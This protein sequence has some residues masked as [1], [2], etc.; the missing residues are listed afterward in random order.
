MKTL[1]AVLLFSSL[2]FA[3]DKLKTETCIKAI[4]IRPA[5]AVLADMAGPYPAVYTPAIF[6]DLAEQALSC[7]LNP[8]LTAEQQHRWVLELAIVIH[9]RTEQDK[10]DPLGI[11]S[12]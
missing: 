11:R 6:D 4:Q 9:R 5:S 12:E 1:L 7:A 3:T 8:K 2:T 10:T